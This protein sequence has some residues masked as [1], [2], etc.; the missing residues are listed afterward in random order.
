MACP[1]KLTSD[2]LEQQMGVNH[3][4][5]FLLTTLLL[6]I[7]E[8]F[9]TTN[10]PSRVINVSSLGNCLFAPL[11]VGVRLDDFNAE[12]NYNE[13]IRYGESKLANILF[14]RELTRRMT[15]EGKN[16]IA[17]SLHPGAIMETELKRHFNFTNQ[18]DMVSKIIFNS[19]VR[20]LVFNMYYKNTVQG[21]A[22]SVFTALSP[23]IIPSEHYADCGLHTLSP[24]GACHPLAADVE[25]AKR[26][27]QKTEEV[28]AQIHQ[29]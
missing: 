26:L 24:E 23:D 20:K 7:L 25:L 18:V 9:G 1:R 22:T 19:R 29:N 27:W 15:A 14:T 8:K 2:G 13:W 3:V 4:G 10:Q 12:K 16:I 17:V 21:A 28:I 5:H 6:P 11:D